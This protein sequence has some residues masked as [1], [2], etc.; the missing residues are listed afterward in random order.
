MG[1]RLWR[2]DIHRRALEAVRRDPGAIVGEGKSVKRGRFSAGG[3][4]DWQSVGMMAD[5]EKGGPSAEQQLRPG[6]DQAEGTSFDM[7]TTKFSTS[8]SAGQAHHMTM[9]LREACPIGRSLPL[10]ALPVRV[11]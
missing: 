7:A 3:L 8:S 5:V 9:L 11:G 1:W 4:T 2:E 6:P 10:R